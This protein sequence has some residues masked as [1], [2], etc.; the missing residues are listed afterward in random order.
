MYI[1]PLSEELHARLPLVYQ[2]HHQLA[3]PRLGGVLGLRPLACESHSFRIYFEVLVFFYFLLPGALSGKLKPI[4]SLRLLFPILMRSKLG[5][6][7]QE[8]TQH[9]YENKDWKMSEATVCNYR[10]S[11]NTSQGSSWTPLRPSSSS[12]RSWGQK[13]WPQTCP[14]PFASEGCMLAGCDKGEDDLYVYTF[15]HSFTKV[16]WG[17]KIEK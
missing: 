16:W 9:F 7:D 12:R 11:R 8:N 14:N 4:W 1:W 17:M 10:E 2:P 3:G 15:L 5:I 13:T 6:L